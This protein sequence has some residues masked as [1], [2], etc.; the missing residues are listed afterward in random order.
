MPDAERLT[1]EDRIMIRELYARYVWAM[2]SGDLDSFVD[3]YAPGGKLD[4][5][6][7]AGTHEEIRQWA[8][9]FLVDS[10]FPGSQHHYNQF[11]M[12]GDGQT[13]QVRA[14]WARLYRLPGTMSC[15]VIAQGYYTDT[16]VKS[17]GQW[18]FSLKRS[19]AAHE[20]R[21]QKFGQEPSAGRPN[22]VDSLYD[23]GARV[24]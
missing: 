17:D 2:D 14:Y 5:G 15:E 9:E 19:H 20:L 10:G 21:E 8:A 7:L 6:K 22:G 3:C 16:V 11:V 13:C 23:L 12:D 1:L 4:V 24:F 18:K